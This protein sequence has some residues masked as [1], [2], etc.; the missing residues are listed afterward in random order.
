M[1][2]QLWLLLRG[3]LFADNPE[4]LQHAMRHGVM[5]EE[6]ADVSWVRFEK[7]NGRLCGHDGSGEQ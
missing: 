6:P 5:F 2:R 4:R 7:P 1:I 3:V